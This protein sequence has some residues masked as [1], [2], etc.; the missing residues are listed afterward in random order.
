MSCEDWPAST[1]SSRTRRAPAKIQT[2]VWRPIGLPTPNLQTLQPSSAKGLCGRS[3]PDG[4]FC[5]L[6]LIR[7][8]V[9]RQGGPGVGICRAAPTIWTIESR[10]VPHFVS[11]SACLA[12]LFLQGVKQNAAETL[13]AN[14]QPTNLTP[15]PALAALFRPQPVV[16]E[17]YSMSSGPVYCSRCPSP[18]QNN[19]QQPPSPP[20]LSHRRVDRPSAHEC[21]GRRTGHSVPRPSEP[22]LTEAQAR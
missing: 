5:T 14:P 18:M 16:S 10:G 6:Q 22:G 4:H 12:R 8:G 17:S 7:L 9:S 21:S 20:Q 1:I 19:R 11:T 2:A 13:P 15:S 3:I